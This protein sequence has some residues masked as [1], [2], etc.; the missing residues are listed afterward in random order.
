MR[1]SVALLSCSLASFSAYVGLQGLVKKRLEDEISP[2]MMQKLEQL[3]K[4]NN[5]GEG[6][7]VGNDVSFQNLSMCM[8]VEN[9]NR[10]C[11]TG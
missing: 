6:F 4:E 9:K 10:R 8:S 2:G 3:L 7:F 1:Q 11:E 5:G